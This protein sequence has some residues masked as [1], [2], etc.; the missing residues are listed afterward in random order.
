M[1]KRLLAPLV[2]ALLFAGCT[3]DFVGHDEA[4]LNEHRTSTSKFRHGHLMDRVVRAAGKDG[5]SVGLIFA[6]DKHKVLSRYDEL[7]RYKVLSRYQDLDKYKVLS[8]YEYEHVFE[9]FAIW[10]NAEHADELIALMATDPDIAWV[11]PDVA[12][13]IQ[14]QALAVQTGSGSQMLPWS[15]A[16]V[17]A[18]GAQASGVHLFVMD[19]GVA[20]ADVNLVEQYD[21]A[22][23]QTTPSAVGRDEDGHGTHIAGIAAAEDNSTGLLGI[24]PGAQVH[25][26]RVLTGN[27]Q[28]DTETLDVSEAIAAIEYATTWKLAHPTAPM[29]VN[30]SL[31]SDIGTRQ[32]N[33]LDDAIRTSIGAGIT[34]VISAGNSGINADTVTPAHVEEAITVGSYGM[35]GRFSPFSNYGSVVDI[36]APGE[37]IL[38]LGSKTLGDENALI[39]M[40]GT[41]MAA[42]H[43]SG[44]VALFLS[45]N[46]NASPAQ[47]R[48]AMVA[49][50]RAEITGTPSYTTNKTVYLGDGQGGMMD[51]QVLPFY[52][53]A[54][55]SGNDL[56]IKRGT[57]VLAEGSAQTNANVL[58]LRNLEVSEDVQVE[59]FG[60]Y[61][62]S[63]LGNTGSSFQP[64]HNPTRLPVTLQ[65]PSVQAPQLDVRMG[66]YIATRRTYGDL[67]LSGHYHLGTEDRP[68]V[69]YVHGNMITE[70]DVTISGYGI[71]MVGNNIELNHDVR[72][73]APAGE[74]R[75]GLFAAKNVKM[76]AYGLEI[77]A[78]VY[79]GND[80][81]L[82]RNATVYGSVTA[83]HD[84]IM[85]HQATVYYRPVPP[86]LVNSF[87][88]NASGGSSVQT[89]VSRFR[90]G[91]SAND[92]EEVSATGEMY[93]DS[94]DLELG[95]DGSSS[96][97][98]DVIG[99]RFSNTGLPRGATITKAYLQFQV[100]ETDSKATQVTI[101]GHA[102]DD[103]ASFADTPYNISSRSRTAASTTWSPAAWTTVGEAGTKQST[104]DLSSILQEIV[105]RPG[106]SEDDL[107]LIITGSGERTA[108]SYDGNASAAPLLHVE[109][110]P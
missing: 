4:D 70:G 80:V 47:V 45:E 46:P 24:A 1:G 34:Y 53:Y 27:E 98:T 63:T 36:L 76:E 9:G 83:K 59:G 75:L 52:Q 11:E 100:D 58:A 69:W 39:R 93:F 25:S 18:T 5:E 49:S 22:T 92:A 101:Q 16:R 107:A 41:S 95:Q 15:V 51:Q 62:G 71:F 106:W 38:S 14:P 12:I 65:T 94:S 31:G 21:L 73:L 85:E 32:Y 86:V 60:Y 67:K 10:A 89:Q 104:P 74:Q 108:E 88:D 77:S 91:K 50:G 78:L 99:L 37:E 48:E 2:L 96:H 82:R 33:A 57:H 20:N 103:A 19:T 84:L 72:T 66:Q 109:W 110:H 35:E 55:L 44:A 54:L 42:A 29:V 28:S 40:S 97:P 81:L 23:G 43:V 105:D 26:L 90:I 68:V 7:D 64:R 30:F 79:A 102:S 17:G 6:L 3:D 13:E 61:V 87:W 56:K 8:R